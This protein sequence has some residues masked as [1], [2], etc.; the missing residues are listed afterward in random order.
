MIDLNDTLEG[1]LK[2]LRALI[3]STSRFPGCRRGPVGRSGSTPPRSTRSSP[4]SASTRETPSGDAGTIV[5]ETKNATF[6][7][8][9]CAYNPDF[10]PGDFVMLSVSDNGVGMDK[11]TAAG[12]SSRSHH[13]GAGEGHRLGLSTVYGIVKQ[14][15]GFINVYSEP[16]WH[17]L[18]G[19]PA[20]AGAGNGRERQT[21]RAIPERRAGRTCWS[22]TFPT[23]WP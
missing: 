7:E 19:L 4:T 15:D 11:E 23:S 6:D 8:R 2:M 20:P 10:L 12:S 5:I 17:D 18:Q 16:A 22:R 14:N 21:A 1:M 9:Y 3:G 13:Q